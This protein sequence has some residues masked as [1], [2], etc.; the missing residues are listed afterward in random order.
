MEV[1]RITRITLF[2]LFIGRDGNFVKTQ[3]PIYISGLFPSLPNKANVPGTLLRVGSRLALD[4]INNDA[5]ILPGYN[6]NM[7][8]GDSKVS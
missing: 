5:S 1:S 8:E 7:T 6:L 2:L 4:H 3:I